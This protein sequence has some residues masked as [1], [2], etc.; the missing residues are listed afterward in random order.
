MT[1]KDIRKDCKASFSLIVEM[2]HIEIPY[3]LLLP[4]ESIK[5]LSDI[6]ADILIER[7]V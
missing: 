6:E 7:K 4:K 5:F 3:K 2:V 1:S